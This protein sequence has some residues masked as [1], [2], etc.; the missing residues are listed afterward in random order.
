M[1]P[2]IDGSLGA[3]FTKIVHHDTYPGIDP[4]TKS[5]C[6]GKVVFITGASKGVG[7]ATAISYAKAGA[8]GIAI[9][10]R[11]DLSSVVSEIQAAAK[12]AGKQAPKV[13]AVKL[14]V[15]DKASVES[16]AKETE[17][18]FGR[19]DILINNA[20]ALESFVPLLESDS[21]A[22]WSTWEVNMRGVYWC[23]KAFLPLLL[24]GGD[25]TIINLSSIGALV[26]RPGASGYQTTKNAV[27]RFTEF[28][29]IDYAD[30]GVLAY[31]IH[32][33]GVMTELAAA[34]PL[35]M[36]SCKLY[37]PRLECVGHSN[38]WQFLST[39]LKCAGTH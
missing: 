31:A 34:M 17:K 28:I 23:T 10:A 1:L 27:L 33:G 29:N 38:M 12:A 30:Q 20:G 11:S 24:K 21:D 2:L 15:L 22:Y 36:H 35:E 7:L 39:R 6:S 25:K 32:P 9:G 3:T 16:A 5:D 26:L 18:V 19:L 8:E 14:D 13:L 4:A 37:G